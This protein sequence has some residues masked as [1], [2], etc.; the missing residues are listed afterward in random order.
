MAGDP[1]GKLVTGHVM[2]VPRRELSAILRHWLTIGLVVMIAGAG[3]VTGFYGD[4][5][6]FSPWQ[7]MLILLFG[8]ALAFAAQVAG[9]LISNGLM[10]GPVPTIVPSSVTAALLCG[11]SIVVNLIAQAPSTVPGVVLFW[12][13][14]VFEC[15]VGTMAFALAALPF[16][17]AD[18]QRHNLIGSVPPETGVQGPDPAPLAPAPVPR[19]VEAMV[20]LDKTI[21]PAS[22]IQLMKAEGIYVAI[23]TDT[24][25][26]LESKSLQSLCDQ[27]P[28]ALGLRVHRSYWVA[29]RVVM[30]VRR[31]G[32]DM[33][34]DLTDGTQVPVARSLQK[35]V[36]A[37]LPRRPAE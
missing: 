10:R 15:E 26:F 33:V 35:E 22:Q 29:L 3:W 12:V 7:Q 34:I 23:T 1:S 17:R 9:L 8:A 25:R 31:T 11:Y 27:I 18:I 32:R 14:M 16:I 24:T 28:P 21:V 20:A 5:S 6:A 36:S 2:T 19:A 30:R 4:M 13:L 37:L